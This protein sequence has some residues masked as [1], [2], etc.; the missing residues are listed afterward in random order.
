MAKKKKYN[1]VEWA[2][3]YRQIIIMLVCCMM[4]FGIYALTKMNKKRGP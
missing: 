2:M 1:L 3:H 4:A